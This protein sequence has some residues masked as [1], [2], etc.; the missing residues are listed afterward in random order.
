MAQAVESEPRSNTDV[1]GTLM[2]ITVAFTL[3]MAFRSFVLEGF[4]IP[5]GSMG[6]TLMGAH[7]RM[8]GPATGFDYS[9]DAG[10]LS[11][12]MVPLMDPMISQRLG[13]GRETRN[14]LAANVRAG[15]RVLVLKPLFV[16]SDP[17]RWDVVVFKNPTDPI[18]DRQNFIKR[19]VGLPNETLLILDG[20]IFT[21]A[22]GSGPDALRI[23]R[24]PEYVQRAVWQ[25]VY[26]SD[27]QPVCS[28]TALDA[29]LMMRWP[30]P[31]WQPASPESVESG[32]TGGEARQ[33]AELAAS[34]VTSP[35][36]AWTYA[37][38]G[39][40]AL[41]WN[42]PAW[43][44]T[45]WNSYN[46][47][48]YAAE[49]SGN[50]TDVP[51]L[52][53]VKDL[54]LSAVVECVDM[55]RFRTQFSLTVGRHRMRFT[56]EG[57]GRVRVQREETEG[58]ALLEQAEYAFTPRTDGLVAF[59][60]WHVDQQLWVF[61]NEKLAGQVPYEFEHLSERIAATSGFRNRSVEQYVAHPA[62]GRALAPPE[63]A[64]T[65]DST[66]G[67]TLHRVR[68]DRDLYYR[69]APHYAPVEQ[70]PDGGAV[71]GAARRVVPGWGNDWE[72]PARLGPEEFM[73]LGDNSAYSGDSRM[74]GPAHPL[75]LQT[76]GDAQPG[77]VHRQMIVGK[78]WAVYFPAPLP[79]KPGGSAFIPDF[80]R[81]RF[82]R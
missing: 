16:V 28:S 34:W 10:G 73:M 35:E 47:L 55:E 61:V 67:F 80:G 48:R 17:Q 54:R 27:Y 58:G 69:P 12:G 21:G 24:K 52:Y 43:P 49:T 70:A 50:M 81:L 37:K 7:V 20:D 5:T 71:P 60:F 29:A 18:S 64:W 2:S 19:V 33:D 30:G 75:A 26:D 78:A 59:E 13:V 74:W 4:V 45:D 51:G 68:V 42:T 77:A 9:M 63:L 56:L 79:L 38:G 22:P 11:L 82:I 3:A 31:P 66:A 44:V 53:Q 32:V 25:L 15:D 14:T 41:V 40:A 23:Q 6:P 72:S 39:P 62:D 1:I 57:A 36:R 76:F 65:F 8:E 46:I